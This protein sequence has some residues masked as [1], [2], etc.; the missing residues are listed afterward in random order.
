MSRLLLI[1]AKL[2]PKLRYRLY[3]FRS[4]YDTLSTAPISIRL[5]CSL[6][7]GVS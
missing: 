2:H 1:L 4:E 7:V 5:T 3:I 6:L